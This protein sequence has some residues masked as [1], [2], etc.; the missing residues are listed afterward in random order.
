MARTLHSETVAFD[1]KAVCGSFDAAAGSLALHSVSTCIALKS[2]DEK[3]NE[4]PAVQQLIDM[5]DLRGAVVT[6]DAMHCQRET[7]A[8]IVRKQADFVLMDDAVL[9]RFRIRRE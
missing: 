1:G 8:K 9:R 2:V 3:S 4:I 6:A 7:A 5:L